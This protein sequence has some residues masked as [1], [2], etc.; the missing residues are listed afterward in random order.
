MKPRLFLTVGLPGS[1]KTTKA[2]ELENKFD[3]IRFTPDEW[4]LDIYG[5]DLNIK[6]RDS[7]RSPVEDA[8]WILATSAI[9]I[10]RNVVVDYG[11]WAIEERTKFRESAQACGAQVSFVYC[12]ET[13]DVLWERVS[14]REES[15][16]GTL[17]ISKELL[18]KGWDFFQQLTDEEKTYLYED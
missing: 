1:G 7:L 8:L 4:I 16:K 17:H 3:A 13:F 9:K 10:G 5:H 15:Q 12:H 6:D 14:A 18:Q 11:L 2:K